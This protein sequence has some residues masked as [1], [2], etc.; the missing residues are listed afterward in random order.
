MNDLGV[1]L[2]Q[3]FNVV[4]RTKEDGNTLMNSFGDNIEN[5]LRSRGRY[6]SSLEGR[7]NRR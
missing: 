2:E 6:S 5:T 7:E 4:G 3:V 1:E